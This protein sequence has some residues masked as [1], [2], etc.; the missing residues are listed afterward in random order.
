MKKE[1]YVETKVI[2]GHMVN[3]GLDDYG[4]CYFFEFVDPD[5]ELREVSCGT[6]N[7]NYEEE[8][9]YYMN[10]CWEKW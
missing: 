10:F 3:I 5:G 6:Y 8:I 1:E 9:E 7:F 4:Q 2:N